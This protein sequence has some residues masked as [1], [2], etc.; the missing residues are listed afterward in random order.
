MNAPLTIAA[1]V[2][3][4]TAA[5][6]DET[7]ANARRLEIEAEIVAALPSHDPEATVKAD[8]G[9]FRV[10]VTYKVTRSVDS[11]SLQAAWTTLPEKA[12]ACFAWKA[13]AKV[14]EL[15]KLQ[16]FLPVEYQRLA[17]Y[18]EAK[19]AKPSV[20]VELIEKEAA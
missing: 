13:S 19:P 10:K 9:D 5:K 6:A 11:T 16:E 12:Q 8:V 14:G 17:A 2:S 7:A 15:R 1:L 20:V 18:I 3:A 4:W